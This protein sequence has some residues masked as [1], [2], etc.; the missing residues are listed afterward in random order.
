MPVLRLL[1]EQSSIIR[2]A[3]DSAIG[4]NDAIRYFTITE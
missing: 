4:M 2:Q 1:D 3:V